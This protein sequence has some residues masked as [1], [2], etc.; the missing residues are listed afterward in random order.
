LNEEALGD[1]RTVAEEEIIA[2]SDFEES[3]DDDL[4]P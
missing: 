3:Q 1:A 4:E 2:A